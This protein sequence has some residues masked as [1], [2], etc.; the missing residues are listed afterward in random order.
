MDNSNY[1]ENEREWKLIEKLLYKMQDSD[2]RERRW[3]IFFRVLTFAYLFFITYQL[4]M[5]PGCQNTSLSEAASGD[6][7]AVVAVKGPIMAD[8]PTSAQHINKGL[9]AAFESSAKAVLIDINSPGG[10]PVQSGYVYDEIRRLKAL[11]PDT[12]VYAVISDLGASGAY[13]IAAAAD[14]IYVDKASIVGS[15]GV[16]MQNFNVE[17]MLDHLGIK[18]RT[19]TAGENKDILSPFKSLTETQKAHVQ[20][21]L[22]EVHQQFIQAVK[23]GRGERLDEDPAIFSGLFWSGET[24]VRLG[25]AD[26]F[27]NISSIS[28]DKLGTETARDFSHKVDP[29]EELLRKYGA[30]LSAGALEELQA[31]SQTQWR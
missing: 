9:Q 8:T 28:R 25:L 18:A 14:E 7:T 30:N 1:P 24:A 15:I 20:T 16:I 19:L 23:T 12:P 2:R 17:D 4:M 29:V 11:H 26:G 21:M 31:K 3:R 13:F 22:D 6:F 27:G 10:S 5:T